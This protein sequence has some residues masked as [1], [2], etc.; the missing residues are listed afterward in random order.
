MLVVTIIKP[1]RLLSLGIRWVYKGSPVTNF[2]LSLFYPTNS[3][4]SWFKIVGNHP[5]P[6]L[7]PIVSQCCRDLEDLFERSYVTTLL[8]NKTSLLLG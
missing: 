2:L 4:I 6:P 3:L 1:K 8:S 7:G 5:H